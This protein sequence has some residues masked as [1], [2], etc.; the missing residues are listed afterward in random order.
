LEDLVTRDAGLPQQ[1]RSTAKAAGLTTPVP[2]VELDELNS[3]LAAGVRTLLGNAGLDGFDVVDEHWQRP[4]LADA[5]CTPA[6]RH[7]YPHDLGSDAHGFR[8]ISLSGSVALARLDGA[9][10]DFVVNLGGLK[11]RTIELGGHRS[12]VPAVQ[13]P[14]F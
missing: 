14:L 9:D 8:I 6:F 10:L 11:G 2:A 4:G 3:R 1:V 13:Q 5:A 7:A 12:H